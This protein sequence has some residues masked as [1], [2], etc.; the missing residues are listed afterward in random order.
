[1]AW[2]G[3]N[4]DGIGQ[5][6]GTYD[7][8]IAVANSCDKKFFNGNFTLHTPPSQ[9]EFYNYNSY[10]K[11]LTLGEC[12]EVLEGLSH[13]YR[14]PL[15]CCRH[16]DNIL[17]EDA[18]LDGNLLIAVRGTITIGNNVRILP[19]STIEFH[20]GNSVN[21]AS[22]LEYDPNLG[23]SYNIKV[24]PEICPL[25]LSDFDE[26]THI[27]EPNKTSPI[28]EER[29]LNDLLIAPNPSLGYFTI[30]SLK[31]DPRTINL[32]SLEGKQMGCRIHNIMH[33]KVDIDVNHVPSGF[34][35]V[36]FKNENGEFRSGK[37]IINKTN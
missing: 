31:I 5:S 27:P 35:F 6:N 2:N 24:G 29:G 10:H 18:I 17:I 37:I 1:M 30:E 7:Y 20:A 19:G 16:T 4:E 11:E 33:G 12:G 23:A 21:G 32:L 26:V 14:P 25:R 15:P 22:N 3:K 34:Y 13:Y 9:S 8:E 36:T 28:E